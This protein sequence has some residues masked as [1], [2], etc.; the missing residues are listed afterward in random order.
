MGSLINVELAKTSYNAVMKNYAVFL[1]CENFDIQ[2]KG[3]KQPVG[4]FTTVCVEAE[5]N[6]AASQLAVQVIESDPTLA[7]AFALVAST[8]PLI[9]VKVVHELEPGNKMKSTTYIF[10]TMDKA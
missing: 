1:H 9:E 2:Y 5:T 6:E 3:K 8:K 10:F 7:D 4:F